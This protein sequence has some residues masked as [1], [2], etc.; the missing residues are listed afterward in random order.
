M[1]LFA[2]PTRKKPEPNHE[3]EAC[4]SE[5]K[6]TSLNTSRPLDLKP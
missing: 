5:T 6:D 4:L 1:H 2:A 3:P